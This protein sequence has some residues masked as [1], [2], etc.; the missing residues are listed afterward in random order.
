M[1]HKQF[2]TDLTERIVWTFLQGFLGVLG[3]VPIADLFTTVD[4]DGGTTVILSAAGAGV[5]A[6]TSLLKGVA[7]ARLTNNGTAQFIP[8]GQTYSHDTEVES[9]DDRVFD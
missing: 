5:A 8:G 6:V 4:I 3:G 7:A 1:Y 2:W 9:P